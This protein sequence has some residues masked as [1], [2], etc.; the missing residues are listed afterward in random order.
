MSQQSTQVAVATTNCYI[1]VPSSGTFIVKINGKQATNW[2]D[3]EAEA[4]DAIEPMIRR[5]WQ[6]HWQN[7]MKGAHKALQAETLDG[8]MDVLVGLSPSMEY[9]CPPELAAK[10]KV[11]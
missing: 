10:A 8:L 3:L 2:R 4:R 11:E 9:P 6:R 5:R 1:F 7:V